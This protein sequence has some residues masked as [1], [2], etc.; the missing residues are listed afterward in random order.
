MIKVNI[1]DEQWERAR[2]LYE[3][4]VL[5][6][7]FT[8]GQGNMTGALGE[9]IVHDTWSSKLMFP[10][11]TS[12]HYDLLSRCGNT[13]ID[14]KSKKISNHVV[15]KMD[16]KVAVSHSNGLGINQKCDWYVFCFITKD[17]TTGYIVGWCKKDRFISEGIF[18]RQGDVDDIA[19]VMNPG[20]RFTVDTHI[21]LIKDL[22]QIETFV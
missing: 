21:M 14:V 17:C 12:Y 5:N 10:K 13:K 19:Q 6:Q 7:S 9:I 3:F 1:T 22:V 8:Q 20:W 15:P 4:S 2:N 18:K 16:F 11:E